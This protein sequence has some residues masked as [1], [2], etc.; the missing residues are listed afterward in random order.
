M[1][2]PSHKAASRMRQGDPKRNGGTCPC[3]P[4]QGD[5]DNVAHAAAV[6]YVTIGSVAR[7]LSECSELT[8]LLLLL[9]QEPSNLP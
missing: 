3:L 5:L 4:Q 9:G 2:R 8:D 7:L 1:W 6:S